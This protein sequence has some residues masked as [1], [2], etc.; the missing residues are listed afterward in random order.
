VTPGGL[1]VTNAAMLTSATVILDSLRQAAQ[2]FDENDVPDGERYFACH[3]A[4]YHLLVADRQLLD[5]DVQA[6]RGSN[7][8]YPTARVYMAHGFTLLKSTAL[9]AMRT[10][11]DYTN[12]TGDN[13][14][15]TATS[16]GTHA[17]NAGICFTNESCIRMVRKEFEMNSWYENERFAQVI[18]TRVIDGYGTYRPETTVA[19]R[20]S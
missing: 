4:Q 8:D 20:T 5:G 19:F 3:P 17:A 2:R 1:V 10:A 11:G 9:K 16:A 14:T 15:Y 18:T 13:N 12:V 6:V 7:G